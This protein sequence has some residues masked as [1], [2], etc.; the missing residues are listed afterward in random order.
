MMMPANQSEPTRFACAISDVIR[1]ARE[2]LLAAG[3]TQRR[4]VTCEA[5]LVHLLC[6]CLDQPWEGTTDDLAATLGRRTTS[7][8]RILRALERAEVIRVFQAG[9]A[10]LVVRAG[11]M[12]TSLRAPV[13]PPT[14]RSPEFV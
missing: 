3:V 14:V 1:K 11:P 7:T 4:T 9:P 8:R 10:G 13:N 12:I 6:L 5:A 2:S